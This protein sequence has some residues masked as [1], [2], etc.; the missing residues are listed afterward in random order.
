[1]L[2]LQLIQHRNFTV[3]GGGA[4][5]RLN[6]ALAVVA[7]LRSKNVVA[8][9]NSFKRRFNHFNRGG[10]QHIKIKVVTV[11]AFIQDFVKQCD[12]LLQADTLAH[13]VQ[14]LFTHTGLEL[15]VVQ[16]QVS[17]FSPLLHQIQLGHPFGFVLELVRR[18]PNQFAQNIA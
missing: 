13:L 6:L 2:D 8:R 16:K 17:Q 5:N 14:M 15:R 10:R 1:M 7:E 9:N 3:S 18:N 11:D 12:I 4:N